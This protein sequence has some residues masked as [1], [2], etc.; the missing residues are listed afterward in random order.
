MANR[1]EDYLKTIY[2]FCKE[3]GYTRVKEIAEAMKV[4]PSSVTEMLRKL[5]AEGYI[6]Y[7]KRLFVKITEKGVREAEKIIE[8]HE[9]LIKFLV[10]I[11]V[12]ENIARTDA[13]LIEHYLHPE[14]VS[15]LKSF[16]R[17]VEISPKKEP[18]WLNHFKE[19]C[20]T[21]VHPCNEN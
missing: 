18:K 12:P 16:V 8:R 11:G 21:G 20:N 17:F 2:E 14:T 9:T 7:E 1:Y 4:K 10:M 15:R 6:I 13:C 19:F 3:K 5:S